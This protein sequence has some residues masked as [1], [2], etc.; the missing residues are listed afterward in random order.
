M[1]KSNYFWIDFGKNI[2]QYLQQIVSLKIVEID[3][4]YVLFER[5]LVQFLNDKL[6]LIVHCFQNFFQLIFKLFLFYF[7]FLSSFSF[8]IPLNYRLND[9]M[10]AYTNV[11][12]FMSFHRN[13]LRDFRLIRILKVKFLSYISSTI[14][15]YGNLYCLNYSS[16]KMTGKHFFEIFR[17]GFSF[18]ETKTWAK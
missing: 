15:N 14:S 18:S 2:V 6:H 9:E 7:R 4:V 12:I 16:I 8:W 11:S 10:C 3:K 5:L 17:F 1:L 13:M